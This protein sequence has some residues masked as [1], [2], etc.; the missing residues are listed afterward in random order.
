[1]STAITIFAIFFMGCVIF[2]T[3]PFDLNT[4]KCDNNV[5]YVDPQSFKS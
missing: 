3:D 5:A 4:K 1:M 2:I